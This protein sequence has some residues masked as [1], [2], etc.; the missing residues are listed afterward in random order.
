MWEDIQLCIPL[1]T[2]RWILK[3]WYHGGLPMPDQKRPCFHSKFD[4]LY[5]FRDRLF[6]EHFLTLTAA[7]RHAISSGTHPSQNSN[8]DN[9]AAEVI[10]DEL[11]HMLSSVAYVDKVAL[12]TY[13]GGLFVLTVFLRNDPPYSRVRRDVPYLYRGFQVKIARRSMR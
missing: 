6:S 4:R 2:R 1:L 3:A 7:E 9:K 11:G 12:G 5:A 10:R 8:S 13:H